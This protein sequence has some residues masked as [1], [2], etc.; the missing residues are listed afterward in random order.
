LLAETLKNNQ[1]TLKITRPLSGAFGK[2]TS[3]APLSCTCLISA[4]SKEQQG[5]QAKLQLEQNIIFSCG[6]QEAAPEWAWSLLGSQSCTASTPSLL[7]ETL[8]IIK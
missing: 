4:A 7:A 8:K 1:I 3:V 6:L 2:A 5:K